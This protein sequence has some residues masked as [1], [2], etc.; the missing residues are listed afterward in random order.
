MQGGDVKP[1]ITLI[2]DED[3]NQPYST[4]DYWMGKIINMFAAIGMAAVA[5]G[6]CIWRMT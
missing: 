1:P 5:G 2:E 6:L 3:T 4:F